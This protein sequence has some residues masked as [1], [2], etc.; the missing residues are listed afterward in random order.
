MEVFELHPVTP[1]KRF[2]TKA[3]DALREGQIVIFPT[4]T[5]YGMGCSIY[6]K[7]A[8]EKLIFIKGG[9]TEKLFSFIIPDLKDISTYAKVS[10]YAYKKMKRLL[11]GP[12]TFILPAAREVPKR[13]WSKR[14][15]V[16]IRVPDHSIVIDLAKELGH[17]IVS[18]S[19]TNRKGDILSRPEEIEAVLGYTVDMMLAAGVVPNEPSSVVDLS[20]DEPII[21]REGAGDISIFE[22]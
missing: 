16:G 19:T 20:S 1:Q 13:L 12:Y 21:L 7:S 3:A 15:T 8:I 9:S 10:D 4:D 5:Y 14:K 11:P 18:T 6:S 22:E 2:I 17:P